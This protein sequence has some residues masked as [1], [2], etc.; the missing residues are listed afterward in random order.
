[1]SKHSCKYWNEWVL[2]TITTKHF[3]WLRKGKRKR[4]MKET[5]ND[6]YWISSLTFYHR[7]A[8]EDE[9]IRERKFSYN[10]CEERALLA[11]FIYSTNTFPRFVRLRWNL[12]L[13]QV[14]CFQNLVRVFVIKNN[15]HGNTNLL[16]ELFNNFR[17]YDSADYYHAVSGGGSGMCMYKIQ[18]KSSTPPS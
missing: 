11:I 1:M 13:L 6:F 14:R 17:Y 12:L 7:G 8:L 18:F 9:V 4:V 15:F 16:T 5:A 3:F 2:R 10:P